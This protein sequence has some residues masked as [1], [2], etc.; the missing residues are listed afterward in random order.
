MITKIDHI[1]IAVNNLDEVMK[2]YTEKL[3]LKVSNIETLG[4]N[5]TRAA[6]IEI[7]ESK[8]ELLESK[9]PD[10]AIG[11]FVAQRGEGIHH[12]ALG[13][14]NIKT[15]MA[16]LKEHGL[17]FVDKEPRPGTEGTMI[18]F[19]HPKGAKILLELVER[20]E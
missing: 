5:K 11:K 15:T 13:V 9:D 2:I 12:L 8:I 10:S 17:P 16:E 14:Q 6:I 7:G 1:G 4:G 18:A 3:G 20:H 19:I